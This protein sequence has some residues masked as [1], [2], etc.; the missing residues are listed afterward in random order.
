MTANGNKSFLD[1]LNNFVEE[2]NKKSIDA[3]SYFSEKFE[4]IHKAPKFKV[5]DTVK[6]VKYKNISAKVILKNGQK[7]Y[8]WLILWWE[9]ILGPIR[10]KI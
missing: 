8:M 4:S 7:Q 10:L 6:I 2:Y 5:G 9:L 3:D 1:Y